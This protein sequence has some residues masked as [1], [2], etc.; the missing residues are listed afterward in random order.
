MEQI[1]K[2]ELSM[3]IEKNEPQILRKLEEGIKKI[4][5]QSAYKGV[6]YISFKKVK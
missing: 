6:H 2:T 1:T 5:V 3:V 4:L